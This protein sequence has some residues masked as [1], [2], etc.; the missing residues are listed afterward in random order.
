MSRPCCSGWCSRSW[1]ATEGARRAT[2]PAMSVPTSSMPTREVKVVKCS[3][4]A[5]AQAPHAARS[6]S[7]VACGAPLAGRHASKRDVRRLAQRPLERR[8][9]QRCGAELQAGRGGTV[10]VDAVVIDT[11]DVARVDDAAAGARPAHAEGAARRRDGGS[12]EGREASVTG[13]DGDQSTRLDHGVARL[14]LEPERTDR[15]GGVGGDLD[16]GHEQRTQTGP[17]ERA[18]HRSADRP[19]GEDRR[20]AA[21]TDGSRPRARGKTLDAAIVGEPGTYSGRDRRARGRPAG[22]Q[23]S[24]APRASPVRAWSG[25]RGRRARRRSRPPGRW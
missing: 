22:G 2:S 23:T 8:T 16:R 24:A 1:L 4:W 21:L 6:I 15:S 20:R 17:A 13:A 19:P 18:Q 3:L 14:D 12:V 11:P 9:E 25:S 7:I 10:D 5:A